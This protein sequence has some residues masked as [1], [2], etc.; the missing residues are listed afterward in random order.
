MWYFI[1]HW[2]SY[3]VKNKFR[4][5]HVLVKNA[6]VLLSRVQKLKATLHRLFVLYFIIRSLSLWQYVPR[7]KSSNYAHILISGSP[8][9]YVVSFNHIHS[10]V[11][12]SA[13]LLRVLKGILIYMY[14]IYLSFVAGIFIKQ[15]RFCPGWSCLAKC[16]MYSEVNNERRLVETFYECTDVRSCR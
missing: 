2:V 12:I 11:F 14:V 3:T 5:S 16:F 4:F 7:F 13:C 1:I 10:N 9:L 15:S 8:V 6:L